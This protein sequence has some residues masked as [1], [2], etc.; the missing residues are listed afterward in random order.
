[1]LQ[2]KY[3]QQLRERKKR[4][5][6]IGKMLNLM[7]NLTCMYRQQNLSWSSRHVADHLGTVQT[8]NVCE[9]TMYRQV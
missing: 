7:V 6:M 8:S 3:D 5:P 2:K 1:M 4:T 9:T